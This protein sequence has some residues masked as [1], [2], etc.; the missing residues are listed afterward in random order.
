MLGG[1]EK[2]VEER[3][4]AAQRKGAFDN[5]EGSGK[6][7]DLDEDRHIPEDLRLAHKILK[8]AD[9]VPP[10]IELRKEVLRA[11]DLLSDMEETAEKYRHLQK[12]NFLIMKLN[13]ARNS[14]V[15]FEIPQHYLEKVTRQFK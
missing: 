11:E 12:L 6:P 7:L 9:C 4:R 5:L 1:F 13:A 8:N 10:E 2:I 14:A 15:S 3:I